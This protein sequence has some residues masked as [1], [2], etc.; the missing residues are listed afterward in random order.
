MSNKGDLLAILSG[1]TL[2]ELTAKYDN[3]YTGNKKGKQEVKQEGYS[4]TDT[5][6][7]LSASCDNTLGH[8]KV[9]QEVII[10][11]PKTG[12][13]DKKKMG[14]AGGLWCHNRDP[15]NLIIEFKRWKT[16]LK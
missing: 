13:Y 14:V 11:E 16:A 10:G 3:V 8:F 12:K 5:I 9:K 6:Q 4:L 7:R 15:Y 1:D 2:R